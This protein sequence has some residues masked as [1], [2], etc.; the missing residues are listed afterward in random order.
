MQEHS[1]FDDLVELEQNSF[2]KKCETCGKMYESA[3]DFTSQTVHVNG[4]SG[5]KSTEGDEGETILE[6]FR[7]CS[8]GSTLLDFFAD[9]RDMSE[10]GEHRRKSFDTVLKHLVDKGVE[11]EL[12]RSELIYYMKHKKSKLLEELGVFKARKARQE[13]NTQ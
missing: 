10:R 7:N 9:R 6:L 13:N 5:L 2:P 3:E 12:A 4:K 8:C 11:R 1:L